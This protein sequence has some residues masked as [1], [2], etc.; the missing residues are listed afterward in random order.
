MRPRPWRSCLPGA[1]RALPDL[2]RSI[3]KTADNPV[4][5]I[6]CLEHGKA[7]RSEFSGQPPRVVEF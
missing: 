4:F 7:A 1:S 6:F 2:V 5:E 3:Y